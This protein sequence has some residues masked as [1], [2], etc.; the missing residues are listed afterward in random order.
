MIEQL[1][2]HLGTLTFTYEIYKRNIQVWK[3]DSSADWSIIKQKTSK[4]FWKLVGKNMNENWNG[5]FSQ[6]NLII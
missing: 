4:Q 6:I 5:V 2:V 3:N 1:Y